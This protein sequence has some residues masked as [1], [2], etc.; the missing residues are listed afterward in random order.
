MMSE[1]QRYFEYLTKRSTLGDLY[2]R[3]LLYPKVSR[4]LVGNAR[5]VG[6]GLGGMV[7]YRPN[8]IGV[9]INPHNVQY[10]KDRGLAVKLMVE[11]HL[12]FENAQFD[13]VLLDNVLEHL[14]KP[15]PLLLEIKRILVPGGLFVIGVPG[16][17]GMRADS[18]HKIF[19]GEIELEL[20]SRETDFEIIHFFYTP[21][22]RSILLSNNLRQYCVYSVWRAQ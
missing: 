17:L 10:G 13:S 2:R 21:L 14:A 12:P 4:H 16:V 1:S 8:T 15:K 20:L 6:C 5:D 3:F 11:D 7:Q 18:D 19:Y 9:D 22:W